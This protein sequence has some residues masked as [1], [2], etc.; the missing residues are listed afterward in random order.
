MSLDSAF[1]DDLDHDDHDDRD[2][3]KLR[4]YSRS[5][6][7]PKSEKLPK[8]LLFDAETLPE[9]DESLPNNDR[10]V[11]DDDDD[12]DARSRHPVWTP[13]CTEA[14]RRQWQAVSLRIRF[15]LFR[16]TRKVRR[17]MSSG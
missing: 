3:E 14:M 12:A 6:S 15:G 9:V 10:F 16:A 1:P 4:K 8:S 11:D 7:S 5:K 2:R 17:R 13:T